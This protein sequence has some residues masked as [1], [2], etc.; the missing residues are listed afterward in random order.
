[1]NTSNVHIIDK[2]VNGLRK[3]AVELEEFQVQLALGKAEAWD[4][5]EEVKKKFSEILNEIKANL[6]TGI[7]KVSDLKLKFDELQQ[8]LAMGKV[9]TKEAFNDQKTKIMNAIISLEEGLKQTSIGAELYSKASNE[10][11]KFKIKLEI[12]SLKFELGKMDFKEK[13]EEG[14]NEFTRTIDHLKQ[15][16]TDKESEMEKNWDQ[17]GKEMTEAF[18][19]F[20]N[21]FSKIT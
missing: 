18:S 20:K 15:K 10:I 19:H 6:N 11:Q 1:M 21:A 4:K 8:L 13:F 5:Y 9:A 2:I 16:F 7:S 17:F 3:A 12:L 14:K